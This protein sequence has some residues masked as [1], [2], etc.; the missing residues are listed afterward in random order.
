MSMVLT[1]RTRPSRGEAVLLVA[2][3]AAGSLTFTGSAPWSPTPVDA[4]A[5]G[6]TLAPNGN[7]C[8][9]VN[10]TGLHVDTVRVSRNKAMQPVTICN[11]WATVTV[12]GVAQVWRS[13]THQ[14]CSPYQAWMDLAINR[15]FADRSAICGRFFEG[16]E[17][18]GGAA[19]ETIHR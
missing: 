6:C 4:S 9:T 19:C 5:T 1:T 12:S 16:N 10:G 15:D 3:V 8:M 18:Q 2:A 11:Y 17:Q 14:G 13:G 7:T